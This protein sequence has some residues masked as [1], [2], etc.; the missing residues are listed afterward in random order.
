MLYKGDFMKVSLYDVA[1]SAHQSVE[2]SRS[3]DINEPEVLKS[4]GVIAVENVFVTGK[5]E[6]FDSQFTLSMDCELDL[7]VVCSRCLNEYKLH[8]KLHIDDVITKDE[9][10]ID[11]I[12]AENG[13]VDLSMVV[14]DEIMISMSMKSLCSENCKGLCSGCGV[15]LNKEEC[16]CEDDDIDP[17]L[18]GLLDLL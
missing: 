14:V 11:G 5:I 3:I 7:T 9:N 1:K 17:R 13:I 2:F 16:I 15:D 12:V 10:S 6:D 8:K 4:I 18:K